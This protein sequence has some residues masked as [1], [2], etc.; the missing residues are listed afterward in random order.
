MLST[1]EIR[2]LFQ[3]ARMPYRLAFRWALTTG[4]RRFEVAVL[5]CSLLPTPEQLAMLDGEFASLRIRRKGGRE[6][7]IYPPK[8]LVEETQWYILADRIKPSAGFEDYV[9]INRSG[10][11]ISRQ[12]LT[13][14]FRR[15]ADLVGSDATLH[16]LRHTFAV[17]VLKY[18]DNG[19]NG[20]I[21]AAKNS[22]KVLQVLLGHAHI[23]TTE[24]YLRAAEV[25]GRDAM[26]AL[27]S[28]YRTSY[29]TDA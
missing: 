19:G 5:P 12:S 1:E 15:C 2:G 25:T 26:A 20:E 14:E 23:E 16:H 22:L 13:K 18:L 8:S 17:H 9:F 7:A 27:E 24:I 6:L 28:L 10:L 29:D 4:M 11:S 3:F 21:G